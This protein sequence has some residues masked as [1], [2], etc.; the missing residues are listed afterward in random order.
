MT[1]IVHP[2]KDVSVLAI[3]CAHAVDALVGFGDR[4][5]QLPD[6]LLLELFPIET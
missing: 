2:G 6:G 1:R 5:E 4:L 3:Q